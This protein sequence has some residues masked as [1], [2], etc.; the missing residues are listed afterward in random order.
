MSQ[1]L[2]ILFD[3]DG[4]LI[5]TAPDLMNAHN[6]VMKKFGYEAK[7]VEDMR[8]LYRER[9]DVLIKSM[10]I[11]GWQIPIPTSTMFAWAPVPPEFLNLGSVGFSK[12]L[13]KEAKVAVAPGLAFGEH[14]DGHVRISLVENQ[15]RIRQAARNVR[16]MFLHSGVEVENPPSQKASQ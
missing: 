14:G 5:D 11:A 6:H 1:K 15:Q 9:R 4:T 3:L 12:L 8:K 10:S 2:T 7:S 13:L 16:A